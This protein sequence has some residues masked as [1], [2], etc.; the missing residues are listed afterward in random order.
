LGEQPWVKQELT[1]WNQKDLGPNS[2]STIINWV[3]WKKYLALLKLAFFLYKNNQTNIY[4]NKVGKVIVQCLAHTMDSTHFCFF[5]FLYLFFSRFQVP[6]KQWPYLI[7][8]W[9][10]W[11]LLSYLILIVLAQLKCKLQ[12]FGLISETN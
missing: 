11:C 5:P 7:Y 3:I 9:D 2:V 6:W 12:N 8:M 10:S 4:V 1:L